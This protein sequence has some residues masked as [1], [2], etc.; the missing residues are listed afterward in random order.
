[1]NLFKPKPVS[2]QSSEMPLVFHTESDHEADSVSERESESKLVSKKPSQDK[3]VSGPN[4]K[5]PPKRINSS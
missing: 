2:K 1:M 5:K 3:F 4:S